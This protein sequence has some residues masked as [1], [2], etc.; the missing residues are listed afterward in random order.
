MRDVA[1]GRTAAPVRGAILESQT[2]AMT[3]KLLLRR[4]RPPKPLLRKR[5]RRR[6]DDHAAKAGT[7][8]QDRS[9]RWQSRAQRDEI[10]RVQQDGPAHVFARASPRPLPAALSTHSIRSSPVSI[11]PARSIRARITSDF[12]TLPR[13]AK[14]AA[15]FLSSLT[16]MVGIA[17]RRYYRDEGRPA[18]TLVSVPPHRARRT[19]RPVQRPTRASRSAPTDRVSARSPRPTAR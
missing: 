14:R 4:P 2:V 19:A 3:R 11:G 15:R 12:G 5:S 17:I 13:R 1:G 6:A 9:R 7:S 16:V 8:A 18:F 10:G